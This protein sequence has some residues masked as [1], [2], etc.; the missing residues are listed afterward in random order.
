M[1]EIFITLHGVLKIVPVKYRPRIG[2]IGIIFLLLSILDLVIVSILSFLGS[3]LM[4][5]LVYTDVKSRTISFPFNDIQLEINRNSIVMMCFL[6]SSLLIIR[7]IATIALT[8]FALNYLAMIGNEIS[9]KLLVS[10]LRLQTKGFITRSREQNLFVISTG[11]INLMTGVIGS[12]L[13]ISSDLFLIIIMFLVTLIVDYKMSLMLFGVL[14]VNSL[15][16]TFAL[17][18]SNRGS[19]R[20]LH[21]LNLESE[22]RLSEILGLR[23]EIA[24]GGAHKKFAHRIY[25]LRQE[26]TSAHTEIRLVSYKL[27]ISFEA[28][29][30]LILLLTL[31]IAFSLGDVNKAATTT[32]VFIFAFYRISTASL[33]IQNNILDFRRQL[34]IAPDT[35]EFYREFAEVGKNSSRNSNH[36]IDQPCFD[37]S[38]VIEDINFDYEAN[39]EFRI[40]NLSL[41]LEPGNSLCVLGKSGAGKS[42]ILKLILGIYEPISGKIRLGGFDPK[43]AYEIFPG[44]ISYISQYAHLV[45]GSLAENVALSDIDE[46]FSEQKLAKIAYALAKVDLKIKDRSGFNQLDW[47]GDNLSSGERQRLSLARAF[48]NSS[49]LIIFD[50][51]T[52]ALDN[53]T[54]NIVINNLLEDDII[55]KIIVTH[56]QSIAKLTDYVLVVDNGRSIFFGT[57]TE[58]KNSNFNY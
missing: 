6:C 38:L 10:F 56:N 24:L 8:K 42:T 17:S 36:S 5:F 54:E 53:E 30:I 46:E 35:L 43:T 29:I 41:R 1:K 32:S 3:I 11:P 26:I 33:Q 51:P 49:K 58:F 44:S 25:R 22:S 18:K 13:L 2:A 57:N 37:G 55:T 45:K 23:Y 48:Y 52:N 47:N 16:L 31:L 40:E 34:E 14:L 20:K 9:N 19:A 7:F 28:I 15:I 39:S 27:R 4:R 21:D 50:E 12:I